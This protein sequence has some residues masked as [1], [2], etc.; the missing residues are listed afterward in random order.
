[1]TF[2]LNRLVG[3]ANSSNGKILKCVNKLDERWLVCNI[4]TLC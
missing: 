1:M 3:L 2:N 4:G